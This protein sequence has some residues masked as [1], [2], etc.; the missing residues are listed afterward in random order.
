MLADWYRKEFP[1]IHT[2]KAQ[3][4]T[5]RSGKEIKYPQMELRYDDLPIVHELG[6]E[7]GNY[8]VREENQRRT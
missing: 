1:E 7:A 3:S 6:E 4:I 5:T 8:G 2:G